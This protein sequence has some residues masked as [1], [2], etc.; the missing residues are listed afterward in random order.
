MFKEGHTMH[1]HRFVQSDGRSPAI[2][3]EL[4][5]I[6]ILGLS[7]HETG[8]PGRTMLMSH[9]VSTGYAGLAFTDANADS[10]N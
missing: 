5:A 3:F 9:E 1:W 2:K 8:R 4:A 6:S 10:T 7:G